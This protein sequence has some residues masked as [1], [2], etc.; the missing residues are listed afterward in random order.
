MDWQ[1]DYVNLHRQIERLT[2]LFARHA[3]NRSQYTLDIE[4]KKVAPG[5][6]IIKQIRELPQP[7]TLTQP[8][9]ILAGGQTQLRLFQGE[10]RGSGGVFAYHRLKSQWA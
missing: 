8:T 6:L 5:Q 1:R 3:S 7:V 2:P 10:A 4:Y 9:Q